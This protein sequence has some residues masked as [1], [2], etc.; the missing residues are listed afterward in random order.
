MAFG[1]TKSCIQIILQILLNELNVYSV[2]ASLCIPFAFNK[3][4]VGEV[5]NSRTIDINFAFLTTFNI[6]IHEY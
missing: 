1:G 6:S 4:G 5:E 3:F 2:F